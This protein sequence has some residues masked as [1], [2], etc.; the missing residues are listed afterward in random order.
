MKKKQSEDDLNNEEIL[1]NRQKL[2]QK[3]EKKSSKIQDKPTIAPEETTK[4]PKEKT[5][6][7]MAKDNITSRDIKKLDNS[8]ENGTDDV[9]EAVYRDKYLGG[10][11]EKLD[12]FINSD[13]S[14]DDSEEE[15]EIKERA[16]KKKGF[17]SK[18]TDGLKAFTGNKT[19]TNEDIESI[20]IKFKEDL[21]QKNVGEEISQKLC[22]SIKTSLIDRKTQAFT[23][24]KKTVKICLEEALTKILT[25]KRNV[26]I[27]SDAMKARETGK[28]YV[29]VFIGVNGV[30]KSTNLAKIAYLFKSQGFS[31]MLAACDN[32]RAGA[33]EQI[34]T[35]GRCLDVPVY[36]R[37]YKEDPAEIAQKAIR[38]V[39]F[40]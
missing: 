5:Q 1:K 23:S 29:M 34:K 21:M 4:K 39:I 31:V 10:E 6:W 28:P 14:E 2:A 12:G 26:N 15:I 38:E 33:V 25:P 7:M 36:D 35:H 13:E 11:E 30:G 40:W 19:I 9:I 22:D 18:L 32:F 27:I 16:P 8:K 20:V 3:F 24:L 17:F 37:G